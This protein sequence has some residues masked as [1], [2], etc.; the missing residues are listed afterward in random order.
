MPT[1]ATI[2]NALRTPNRFAPGIKRLGG[3]TI[4]RRSDGSL[5]LL[6]GSD[7]VVGRLEQPTGRTIAL[8]V[9][10]RDDG[11]R[12]SLDIYTAFATDPVISRLR[13]LVP[14]PIAGGVSVVPD[15][16]Q[17][18]NLDGSSRSFPVV[19]MEWIPGPTL[20]DAVVRTIESNDLV[21]MSMLGTQWLRMMQTLT[22]AGF[23]HGN[24][25]PDNVMIRRGDA[26]AIVDY[27][28]AAWP[29]SPRGRTGNDNPAY[30]H[31]SG[32]V[33]FA[34]ERRDDFAALVIA[35]T[36]RALATDPG[37]L[38]KQMLTPG[39]GLLFDRADLVDPARSPKFERLGRINDPETAALA[40]I[41]ASACTMPVDQTPPFEEAT[42]AA[43][44][45]AGRLRRSAIDRLSTP[46]SFDQP[47]PAITEATNASSE[48]LA[49]QTRQA[50]LTRLNA[51]LLQQQDKEALDYWQSSGLSMDEIAQRSVG[52]L[53]ESARDRLAGKKPPAPEPPREKTPEP[54]P[55]PRAGWRVIST[56]ASMARLDAAIEAHDHETVLREWRDIEGTPEASRYAAIVHQFATDYWAMAIRDAARRGDAERVVLAVGQADD[57]GVA[58]PAAMRPVIREAQHRLDLRDARDEESEPISWA[59][60]WPVLAHALEQDS[61]RAIGSAVAGFGPDDLHRLPARER[62]RIELAAHRLGWAHDVR[63]AMRRHDQ[64]R[65][66]ALMRQ[67][68]PGGDRLLSSV[69]RNRAERLMRQ[70]EAQLAV[71]EAIQERD[72]RALIQAMQQLE[73]SGA[74]LPDDLDHRAF[75]AALDRVTLLTALRRAAKSDQS[76]T[77]TLARLVPAAIAA[78]GNRA[79]VQRIVDVDAL[80]K[81]LQQSA[82]IAR[83]REALAS[84]NDQRIAMTATPD[85]LDVVKLLQPEEQ[86][87]VRHAVALLKPGKRQS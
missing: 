55:S 53:I 9:P 27:D 57:A 38:Q 20:A 13:T 56:G 66:E 82:Q 48:R 49:P 52:N 40:G 31:P 18:Q 86:A 80:E 43:R 71:S 61:D 74:Q 69:E 59:A 54:A 26:M 1:P 84:K 50:R 65:L 45:A 72:D 28:T 5:A 32:D 15:G 64:T 14:S 44:A 76:N 75:A 41:L 21:R 62:A 11:D 25:T 6:V 42:R 39:I 35:V 81:S 63:L 22:D 23:S 85:L 8:R 47:S 19:A 4:A 36:L 73:E 2:E 58:I 60:A 34:L 7:A 30:R 78:T 24:L 68:A 70:K 3:G 17:L 12:A 51:M 33:P 46:S 16:L 79:A 77:Q 10:L 87:K 83:L 29:G 67:P 37:M